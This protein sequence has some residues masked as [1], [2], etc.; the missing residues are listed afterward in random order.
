M[1]IAT[2]SK[3]SS[4]LL[5]R[6]ATGGSGGGRF[7]ACSSVIAN[8]RGRNTTATF[9][10]SFF[11]TNTDS[12]SIDGCM[13]ADDDDEC[14][15]EGFGFVPRSDTTTSS[16]SSSTTTSPSTS[17]STYP[18][19]PSDQKSFFSTNTDSKSIDGCMTA[20]DDDECEDEGFGFVPRSDTTS[21]TPSSNGSYP[22]GP[23]DQKNKYQWD[24]PLLMYSQQLTE[25]ERIL[26]SS[27]H[28]FCRSELLPQVIE[29]N[30]NEATGEESRSLLKQLGSMGLL[31]STLPTKYGGS[32]LG[33]V[34]Y[35]IIAM[36]V[37]AID[38]AFRSSMSVQSSLVMY[39]IYKYGTEEQREKYLPLLA[40]GDLVGCFGL[41]EPNHGS[42]P[43][44]MESTAKMDGDH[45]VLN[46][47]KTWI[48]NSP[49]ADVFV[50]WAKRIDIEG[51][52][53]RG[54]L[55]DRALLGDGDGR[56]GTHKIDGKLSLR[57]G[58]TG[59]I[60]MDDVRIPIENEFQD[61][62]GLEGPFS[63]LN[64]AR[65]GISWG[66]LGSAQE[67]M[68]IALD[69]TQNRNQF[70]KPLASNQLIQKKF[71]DISTEITLAKQSCLQVGRLMENGMASPEQISLIKRNSC[72]KSLDIT[73][74]CR[75]MLGGNGISDEYHVMRHMMNLEAVNTY[76]GTHDIHSLILGRA[77]TG[78]PAF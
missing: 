6:T 9:S 52:P 15:D 17:S 37:E 60:F 39:P 53:I 72:G 33:Y 67:C 47:S 44:R 66:V 61:I 2:L 16:T 8:G 69:Y 63:C 19:G 46:G 55:I 27:V 73:R 50:I 54:Y 11:S 4:L 57:A 49:I 36:E 51:E 41:T 65:Y 75:D 30:R 56:L 70:Q 68:N 24:D 26:Q 74:L 48:T 32:G 18:L 77:I 45:I 40:T 14:E 29:L 43:S 76:E 31:G 10:N 12:N 58:V 5:R 20:D 13:T 64:M 1:I 28:A 23:S 42:D 35:G 21:S 59:M 25:N 62:Q 3:S 78:L 38:S 71:S 7:C 34:S 22:F